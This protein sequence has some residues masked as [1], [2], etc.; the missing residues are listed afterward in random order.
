MPMIDSLHESIRVGKENGC[1]IGESDR[2]AR[3]AEGAGLSGY[4]VLR[5]G[6]KDLRVYCTV[7]F[8]TEIIKKERKKCAMDVV[9]MMNL[10]SF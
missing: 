10:G 1:Q 5:E 6:G 8:E 4:W 9:R 3:C 7:L 2:D